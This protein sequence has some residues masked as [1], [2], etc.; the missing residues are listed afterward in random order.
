MKQT[1]VEYMVEELSR[2]T[3]LYTKKEIIEQA[4]EMEKQQIIDAHC[5][6]QSIEDTSGVSDAEQYYNE[7]FK[8]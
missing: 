7:T 8:I 1:A 2:Q 5:D 3:S 6:G 4:K